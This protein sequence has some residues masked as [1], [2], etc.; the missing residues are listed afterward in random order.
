M[1]EDTKE[2]IGFFIELRKIL[3]PLFLTTLIGTVT[4]LVKDS[5]TEKDKLVMYAGLCI[6][7]ILFACILA[8][9]IFHKKLI[10]TFKN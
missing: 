7:I 8:T 6:A 9:F 3:N 2:K 1:S 10:S 4:L 5:L